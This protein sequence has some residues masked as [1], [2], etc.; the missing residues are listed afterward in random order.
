MNKPM[1]DD[2]ERAVDL[3]LEAYV[4]VH[5]TV[6][7]G[8]SLEAAL[9]AHGLDAETW[10]DADADWA[11]RLA[12]SVDTDDGEL[13]DR[14]DA[15]LLELQRARPRAIPALEDDLGAFL[16]FV[17]GLSGLADAPAF[18]EERG[19]RVADLAALEGRW[20]A[21]LEEDPRA[22][23]AALAI[24]AREPGP[25]PDVRMAPALALLPSAADDGAPTSARVTWLREPDEAGAADG[26]RGTGRA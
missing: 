26:D 23:E 6:A 2:E 8:I 13:L 9:A 16:D 22:R 20:A 24:L 5:A 21:R 11:E 1:N 3:A 10:L 15:I 19:V 18:L 12:D 17:R 14:H 25:M 7:S 4:S